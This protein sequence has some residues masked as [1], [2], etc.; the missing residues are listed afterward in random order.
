VEVT[1]T[2]PGELMSKCILEKVY[3][4]EL[5]VRMTFDLKHLLDFNQGQE[6]KDLL[7]IEK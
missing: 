6:G 5:R 1:A 2:I 4:K 7:G 3:G